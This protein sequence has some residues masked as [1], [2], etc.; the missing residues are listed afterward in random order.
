MALILN[1]RV[2]MS[3]VDFF[4]FGAAINPFMDE[5]LLVDTEKAREEH[6]AIQSA[7][8]LAGIDIVN[9]DPPRD[10]QDGVYTANWGLERN[11]TIVLASL[12]DARK[13]EESYAESV[14][15]ALGKTVVHVPDGLRFSGQG[16]ALPCGDILFCGSGYRSD[17]EAQTFVAETLGYRRV[18]LKTIP[19]LAADGTPVTNKSSG[20]PDSLFY[21]IDLALSILRPPTDGQRGLIAW[22]P[23]AFESGSQKILRDLR[24]VDKIEVSFREATDAFACNLVSTGESVI[25][26]QNA[27]DFEAALHAHDLKTITLSNPELAKGG[28][29]IR[30][31]SLTLSNT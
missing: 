5:T 15:S 31:T 24:E 1:Q 17:I 26:N 8:R 18:Q 9:I 21:D 7:L 20:W 28:G 4:E 2:L 16:D 10:C 19:L 13:L 11:D 29:S 3:G 23:D 14:L 22:C 12:P 25:M 27:P 30:C 6:L